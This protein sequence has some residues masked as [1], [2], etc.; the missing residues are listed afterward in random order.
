MNQKKKMCKACW[1]AK[2]A[3]HF[4]PKM[5]VSDLE[6]NYTAQKSVKT[7]QGDSMLVIGHSLIPSDIWQI[8]SSVQDINNTSPNSV[9][10]LNNINESS[11]IALYCKENSVEFACIVSTINDAII[12]NALGSSY[13]VL[14]DEVLAK[15]VQSIA[16]EYLWTAKV[17]YLIENEKDIENIA[18][19]GIDGIA[20][21]D[22]IVEK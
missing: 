10:V 16:N 1:S 9:S 18:K 6:A 20:F 17:I 8:V 4:L 21:K 13:I 14:A 5:T 11:H 12:S 22:Y 3:A 7:K 19:L 15:D 2:S